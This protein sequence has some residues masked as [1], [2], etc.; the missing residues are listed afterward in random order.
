MACRWEMI[1]G[2]F[3]LV[4]SYNFSFLCYRGLKKGRSAIMAIISNLYSF[5]YPRE[6]VSALCSVWVNVFITIGNHRKHY[7]RLL[8]RLPMTPSFG[9]DC[10]IRAM[11]TPYHATLHYQFI[12]QCAN[13]RETDLPIGDRQVMNQDCARIIVWDR[14]PRPLH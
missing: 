7:S 14:R 6:Y 3:I 1:R 13:R 9:R 2:Y 10:L 5:H 8:A 12:T 11:E 4:L